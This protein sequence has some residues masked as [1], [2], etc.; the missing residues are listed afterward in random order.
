[1]I[2]DSVISDIDIMMCWFS[3]DWCI[4]DLLLGGS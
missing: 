1:M 4:S 3:L 2:I